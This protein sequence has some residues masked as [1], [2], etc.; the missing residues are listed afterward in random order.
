[1]HQ[2][3]SDSEETRRPEP[4]WPVVAVVLATASL[5]LVLPQHLMFGSRWLPLVITSL[6]VIPTVWA[7]G[8][9]NYVHAHV[10]GNI[11]S[12]ILSLSMIVSVGLLVYTMPDKRG[13]PIELLRAAGALWVTNILI[14]ATWYW[15]ID[16]GGPHERDQRV[17]HEQGA[18]LFPQMTMDWEARKRTGQEHWSPG[19]VDYLFLAFNTST[20]LSPA[21]TGALTRWAKS[22][23][24]I[25][26][27]I[28]LTI[29]V[30]LA[31]RAI[32]TL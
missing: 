25:Q 23:M 30:L 21:D 28:S 13:T 12:A 2:L 16:G 10:L 11:I 9:K 17:S 24:M 27:L 19:F 22:L 5:N 7:I 31:A 18:F 4:R 6:L 1:M 20:A 14:F 8:T 32:N 29:I 15:R 26:A 3:K